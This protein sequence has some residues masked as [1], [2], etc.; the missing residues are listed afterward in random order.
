MRRSSISA[1]RLPIPQA[2]H[3]REH[4]LQQV[5]LGNTLQRANHEAAVVAAR[6]DRFG[7]AVRR[8]RAVRCAGDGLVRIAA[9]KSGTG[10]RRISEPLPAVFGSV[11]PRPRLAGTLEPLQRVADRVADV[12]ALAG[13]AVMSLAVPADVSLKLID[14]SNPPHSSRLSARHSAIDVSSVH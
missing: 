3:R 6:V 10:A 13:A 9:K 11:L 4:R 14:G 12:E 8:P 7:R 5:F 2:R 1:Q